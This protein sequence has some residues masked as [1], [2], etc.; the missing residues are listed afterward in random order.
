MNN[1]VFIL[2]AADPEMREIERV[3]TEHGMPFVYALHGRKR[4]T[5]PRAYVANATSAPVPRDAEV[6]LIECRVAYLECASEV[7]VDH[8]R[9]GDPGFGLPPE[10]Y[11]EGSSL[12]QLL[13]LLGQEPTQAQRVICAADHCLNH[14][15]GNKCPGVSREELI[16][17][18]TASRSL[19]RGVPREQIAQEVEQARIA[20]EAA[21][22][23]D[24]LGTS[25]AWITDVERF[26]EIADA[27][28]MYGIPY[29]Y[30]KLE[31]DGRVKMG[32]LGAAAPVISA[33]MGAARS[34]LANLYGDPV[35][36]YAG[37]YN[38]AL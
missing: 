30:R 27:S 38:A 4:V 15:Y 10:R 28:A 21:E 34:T 24:I 2:G 32:I 35:R 13:R 16:E 23:V 9:L 22:K 11:M 6:I 37:G 31:R 5:A 7:V 36:G 20:L 3:L 25:V 33:W 8:H 26:P 12:G 19:N 18:R 17:F 1:R 29:M 14:A